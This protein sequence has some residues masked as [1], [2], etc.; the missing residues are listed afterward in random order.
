MDHSHSGVMLIIRHPDDLYHQIAVLPEDF[1]AKEVFPSREEDKPGKTYREAG[2]KPVRFEDGCEY[3]PSLAP[4][5]QREAREERKGEKAELREE[6]T[7]REE[8][9]ERVERG[10][11]SEKD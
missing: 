1:E 8:K 6:K 11:K 2:W 10:V 3:K 9:E 5:E 7:E 4:Q